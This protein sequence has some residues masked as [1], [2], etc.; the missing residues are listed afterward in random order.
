DSDADESDN[1][2]FVG[3]DEIIDS[4]PFPDECQ[5]EIIGIESFNKCFEWR[6]DACPAFFM[7]SLQDACQEAFK[8]T[9]RPV[10]VYLNND[11]SM[12][13]NIFCYKI[14]CST[15]IIDY[16]LQN[17]IAWPWDITLESNRTALEKVWKEMFSTQLP[18][19]LNVE[20]YPMLFGIM[21]LFV[22]KKNDSLT[23][24]YQIKLL[25]KGDTL[26]RT[27]EKSN[28][29]NVLNELPIFKE[30]CD[31][32]ERILSFEFITK[33]GLSSDI[34][35]EI[36]KYLILNDA[37]NVFSTNILLSLRQY[38]ARV[39][40]YQPA[41]EFINMIIRKL[42]SK[43]IV[44]LRLN[45]IWYWT[46]PELDS[47]VISTNVISLILLNLQEINSINKCETYFPNLIRLSL[48]YDNEVSVRFLNRIFEY[49][50]RSIKIFEVHC[51]A[52]ACSH[53]FSNQY[54]MTFSKNIGIEHFLLDISHFPLSS[55]NDCLHKNESCFLMTT[56]DFIQ[57]MSNIRDVRLITNKYNINKLLDLNEW[58]RL[59]DNCF[60]LKKITL[61][62]LGNILQDE[63]LV[64]KIAIIQEGLRQA[65]E[66]QVISM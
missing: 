49:L 51:P 50:S 11:K 44:S 16:L 2:G 28:R 5:D 10:L 12:F 57:D 14:F 25:L 31:E 36:A 22:E 3:D 23:S 32:N 66:F 48:W 63:E 35:L 53:Y 21:R 34:I 24:E 26:M 55:M 13:N 19:S 27:Q 47:L 54:N 41:N 52:L 20:Q 37:I 39:E 29:E 8:S 65:V 60:L 15:I 58:R 40:I 38:E 59:V 62:I 30:K 42:K 1:D 6:Y 7:G 9:R 45:T 33:I 17:Y 46:Q 43:Q 18:D 4:G 64:K 56:I 61:K